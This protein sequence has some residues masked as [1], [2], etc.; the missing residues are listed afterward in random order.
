MPSFGV[1]GSG[2]ATQGFAVIGAPN[3]DS[4]VVRPTKSGEVLVVGREANVLNS[5]EM[6]FQSSD[7]A[8][9]ADHD[10][11]GRDHLLRLGKVP[12]NNIGL[13]E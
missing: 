2:R 5:S 9:L 11:S 13:A 1:W 8:A 12:I 7:E 4:I 10:L 3:H 6:L